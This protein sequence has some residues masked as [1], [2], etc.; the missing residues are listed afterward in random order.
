MGNYRK[1][2]KKLRKQNNDSANVV[3]TIQNQDVL[4]LSVDNPID[5]WVSDS[6][7]SFHTI[8]HR[9]IIEN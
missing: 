7:A 1:N 5:F 9:E 6:G 3:A 2:C 4:L 8:A